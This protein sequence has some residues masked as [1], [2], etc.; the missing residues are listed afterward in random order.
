[1]Q[2]TRFFATLAFFVAI[3]IT[4]VASAQIIGKPGQVAGQ[5]LGGS[6]YTSNPEAATFN[7]GNLDY[8]MQAF[9]PLDISEFDGNE[10][11][12]GLLV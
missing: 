4:S 10:P 11:D 1:M 12:T 7:P 3:G 8:D 9:A 5:P 2:I 6:P